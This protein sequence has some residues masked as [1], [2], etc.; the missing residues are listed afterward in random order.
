[1]PNDARDAGE[2]V[3]FRILEVVN[4]IP[5]RIEAEGTP[6]VAGWAYKYE[7]GNGWMMLHRA[8]E[9]TAR[10]QAA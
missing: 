10:Q 7:R 1:M 5:V 6:N 4:H 2:G 8:Q 3:A 9:T